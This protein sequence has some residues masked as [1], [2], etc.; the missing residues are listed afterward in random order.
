MNDQAQDPAGVSQPARSD[1]SPLDSLYDLVTG[2]EDARVCKDIPSESCNDQPRNFFTYLAANLLTK[3]SDELASAKLV[4]PWLIGWLGAPAFLVGLL[5]P[6]REAGVLVPQLAVAAYI[7]RL[8]LRKGVWIIGSLTSA[9][10]LALMALAA[11]TM[12]GSAAGW[13]VIALLIVFSLARGLCSVS[14]K[15]VLGKTVSKARRGNL[16]GLAAGIAGAMILVLGLT[17]KLIDDSG[18]DAWLF[19]ALLGG[20]A[21][22]FALAAAIFGLIREQPGATQGGGNALS[23]ALESIGLLRTDPLFR[24]FV[25]VRITLLSV[26]LAPPFYVL[27]AQQASGS[28]L[29]ALGL[30]IIAS[31]LAS[32]VSAPVWG[33]LSDHSARLVMVLAAT[34]A[35]V[36]G[37]ATWATTRNEAQMLGDYGFAALFLLLGVAHAGVRLGRKVYLVDMANSETRAAMVAVS[38][39]VIGAVML[40]GGLVGVLGDLYGTGLVILILAIAALGAALYALSLRE[41][42]EP[43]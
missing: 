37:V 36:V 29:G 9:A 20:A 18:T 17:L 42:S 27:L 12:T 28:D 7:R 5:V 3:V 24:R 19:V 34:L 35:G 1:R 6:I 41:I 23:A 8:P 38:N 14:A 25:L 40:A 32:T 11:A 43:T 22:L 2:D 21:L 30:L 10:A 13:V 39:T 26:A 33:R 4:L 15:D 16:M 31:G